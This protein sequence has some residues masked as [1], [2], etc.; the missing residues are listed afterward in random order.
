MPLDL[1]CTDIFIQL[2]Q[3]KEM[4]IHHRK[5]I[6]KKD[7]SFSAML[8]E[9]QIFGLFKRDRMTSAYRSIGFAI[10]TGPLNLRPDLFKSSVCLSHCFQSDTSLFWSGTIR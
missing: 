7:K 6:N 8:N 2:R 3:S 9:K 5:P 4:C 1:Y 10:C